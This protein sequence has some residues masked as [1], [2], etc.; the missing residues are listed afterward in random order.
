MYTVNEDSKDQ[1]GDRM[2]AYEKDSLTFT[3]IPKEFYAVM[4][5]DGRSFSNFVK[6]LVGAGLVIR[7]R[8][9]NFEEVF[10]YAVKQTCKE[11]HFVTAFHQSDEISFVFP[12][13]TETSNLPF[14]GKMAKLLSVVPSF[15]TSAFLKKYHEKFGD[16]PAVSFDA[17]IAIFPTKVEATNMVLWRFFDARRN[18]IQDMAHHKF[19]HKKLHGVSTSDKY[20]MLGR[21]EINPGNF[22]KRTLYEIQSEQTGNTVVRSTYDTITNVDFSIMSFEE[23]QNFIF[24]KNAS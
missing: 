8:D 11:F 21:P 9:K 20:Q 7:P 16:I 13:Q 1:L 14:D 23:R 17:R 15:F 22:I 10:T 2:K 4:R 12:E 6:K 19:G 18:L 5:I 3:H 24:S